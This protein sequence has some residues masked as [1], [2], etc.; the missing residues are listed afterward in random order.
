MTKHLEIEKIDGY[1]VIKHLVGA[2]GIY[3]EAV[4]GG[5]VVIRDHLPDLKEAIQ[6][7]A[8]YE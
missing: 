4:K 6:L 2:G 5:T 8:Q 1:T 3:Y 7:R